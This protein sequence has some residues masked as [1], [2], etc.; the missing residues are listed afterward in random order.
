MLIT[1][2]CEVCTKPHT[3]NGQSQNKHILNHET[4]P[5]IFSEEKISSKIYFHDPYLK[6]KKK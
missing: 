4:W 3:Q 2:S 1:T 5:E 6:R